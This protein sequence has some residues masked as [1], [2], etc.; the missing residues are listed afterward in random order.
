MSPEGASLSYILTFVLGVG[1]GGA[2]MFCVAYDH[3]RKRLEEERDVSYG[4]GFAAGLSD[5]KEPESSIRWADGHEPPRNS[6]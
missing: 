5:V 1:I 2:M 6:L 3:F 4:L